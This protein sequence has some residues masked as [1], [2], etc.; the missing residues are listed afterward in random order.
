MNDVVSGSRNRQRTI[1]VVSSL[2]AMTVAATLADAQ[3]K[4]AKDKDDVLE[5]VVVT[6][7]RIAR[8]DLDRLEPTTVI[9]AA[10]MDQRGYTDVGA[11]LSELP[12]FGVPPSNASNVQ[13]TN[14]I[15]QSYVD[16]YGLGSQRTLTLVDGRRFVSGNSPAAGGAVSPGGQVDLNVIPTKLIERVETISVGGAPIYGADAI[17]GT[18]N[19]ILKHNYEGFDL[20]VQAGQSSRCL[21]YTSPSP[22]DS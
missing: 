5:E 9:S 19:I 3:Q 11:A 17:A 1:A 7:S 8:P 16:L 10:T 21:L 13:S 20:D 22:R 14:G 4:A 18:V 6:G 15:A 2:L 12:G